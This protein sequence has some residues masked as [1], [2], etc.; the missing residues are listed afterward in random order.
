MKTEPFTINHSRQVMLRLL[1]DDSQHW[2]A[3]A[4]GKLAAYNNPMARMLSR[5]S[6]SKR[7]EQ[8]FAAIDDIVLKNN[9]EA[10]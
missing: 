5:E 2:M 7:L 8:Y 6:A 4:N 3:A 10:A 1:W 9:G